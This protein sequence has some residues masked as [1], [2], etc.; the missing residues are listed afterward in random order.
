MRRMQQFRRCRA[1]FALVLLAVM[2]GAAGLDCDQNAQA[3]FRDTATSALADGVK[4]IL[5]GL[6]DGWAAAIQNAGDGPAGG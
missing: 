5:N 3:E 4:T 1:I 2:T 6:I